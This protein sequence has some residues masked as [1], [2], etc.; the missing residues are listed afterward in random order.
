MTDTGGPGVLVVNELQPATT[1]NAV[2]DAYQG[3]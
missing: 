3:N 1:Y 2:I